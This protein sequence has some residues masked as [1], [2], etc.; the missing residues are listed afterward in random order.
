M[1]APRLGEILLREGVITKRQ[2]EHALRVQRQ[3]GRMLGE[4]LV[5]LGYITYEQLAD[6]LAKQLGLPRLRLDE[7]N[8][9][10][11][12]AYRTDPDLCREHCVVP[13]KEDAD[14]VTVATADPLDVEAMDAI[15]KLFP[16]KKV[17]FGVV[18]KPEI[19]K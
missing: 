13:I 6:A 12:L 11:G 2:L 3:T 8:V 19:E 4:V 15:R 14:S 5:E 1:R 10:P 16:D 7:I 9:D 18:S 17:A